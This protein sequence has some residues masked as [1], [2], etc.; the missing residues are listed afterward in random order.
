MASARLWKALWVWG[1]LLAGLALFGAALAWALR[2]DAVVWLAQANAWIADTVI[3]RMGYFGVFL[4]MAIESSFLPLPSE[5]VIPPAGDLARRLPDWHLG[6]VIVVGTLG[7]LAGALCNYFLAHYLGRPLLVALIDRFGRYFRLS[8]AG[9]EATERLYVR[10]G[11]IAT[12][13]GRLLPGIR[14]LISL[15]A[16]LTRMNLVSFCA[17]TT[18]GSAVWVTVLALA[19]YWFGAEPQR[20]AEV[21]REYSHWLVAAA[22]LLIGGYVLRLRLRRPRAAERR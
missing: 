19:G 1:S 13:T 11:G 20:L 12:F 7:S 2:H 5:I 8:I 17:L 6:W 9:Y 4:L 21:L 16:G 14:H 15:P 3:V 22:L 18:L 10:H